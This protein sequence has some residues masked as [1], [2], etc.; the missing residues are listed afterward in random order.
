[1]SDYDKKCVI[2]GTEFKTYKSNKYTDKPECR[3]IYNRNYV[4]QYMRVKRSK[5]K[6]SYPQICIVCKKE[7]RAFK[8]GVDVI[9]LDC[10]L[11]KRKI[12]NEKLVNSG[13][14][15]AQLMPYIQPVLKPEC[16]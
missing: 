16:L 6:Q 5:E 2:C 14:L 15:Q 10:R 4:R 1:M 11:N 9:C 12:F 8:M 3:I 7:F 13:E